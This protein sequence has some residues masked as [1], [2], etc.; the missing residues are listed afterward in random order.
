MKFKT[1]LALLFSIAFLRA[2]AQNASPDQ[3]DT[4]KGPLTIQPIEHASLVLTWNNRTIY[5]DPTGGAEAYEGIKS[6]D[7][8]LLTD[9]HGDHLDKETL[10]ALSTKNAVV[11]AP[12][13]VADQLPENLQQ[14]AVVLNNGEST[15]QLDIPVK[16]IA[17]YNLPENADAMHPKG[18]GNG[19]VLNIGG[20]KIYLSGDTEGTP[21][22]RSLKNIDVAFICM[23]L[24]YT[25]D[26]DQ[27]ANA[28]LDF[29]PKIVYPYHYRGKNGLSDVERFKKMVNEKSKQIEVRL[30]NWYPE[31]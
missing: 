20:K 18:R 16:A 15:T 23:N 31:S 22:M 29:K 21:E 10:K 9:I 25:M 11:I 12:K 19:Y 2:S 27:A 30:K 5:V 17:M 7:M 4:K 28:V 6:P 3:V 1:I 24:P 8:I 13:A 14:Q 26:V